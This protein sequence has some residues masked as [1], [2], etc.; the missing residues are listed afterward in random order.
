MRRS[1]GTTDE[2]PY[3]VAIA[4]DTY[5]LPAPPASVMQVVGIDRD[6]GDLADRLVDR[7]A[8]RGPVARIRDV[9]GDPDRAGG[10]SADVTYRVDDDGCWTGTGNGMDLDAALDR[11]APTHEYA[12]VEGF[13]EASIPRVVTGDRDGDEDPSGK[14]LLDPPSAEAVTA[15]DV[16]GALSSVEPH[17]TLESLVAAVKQSPHAERAGAIATFTGRVRAR[18]SPDDEPTEY[19]EFEKYEGVAARRMATIHEELES[20]PGVFEVAMHHRTGVVE[21]GKDIVFV[22]VLAG[23]REEAFE[24]VADGINRLK[25]EVP[26][27]KRE[28][29]VEEEFWVHERD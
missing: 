16:V 19:L 17:E 8:D 29:T 9:G 1:A 23:H 24:T 11:V 25:D 10:T 18:D 20:R 28:V 14:V 13:P 27:F 3:E 4:T 21:Y 22:V 12:V 15:D 26:L 6:T 5:K 2:R 7:L